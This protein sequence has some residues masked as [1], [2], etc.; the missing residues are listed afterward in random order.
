MVSIAKKFCKH[1]PVWLIVIFILAGPI[2]ASTQNIKMKIPSMTGFPV[3]GENILAFE[4]SDT[5]LTSGGGGG[6]GGV[7]KASFDFAKIKKQ[8]SFSTNELWKR[9]FTGIHTAEVQFEF[10]DNTNVLFYKIVLKDVT[11]NHFSYLAP[12]CKNCQSL[13]HQVWFDY[14]IIEVTDVATGNTVSFNRTTNTAN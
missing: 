6:G 8:N 12:E 3:G 11:V 9:S 13:F 1:C 7:G 5:M 10:Y 2:S 4:V 14:K